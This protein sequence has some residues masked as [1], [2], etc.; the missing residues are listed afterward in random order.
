MAEL[1][2]RFVL[3]AA[4]LQLVDGLVAQSFAVTEGAPSKTLVKTGWT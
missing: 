3:V 2:G 4:G 1:V